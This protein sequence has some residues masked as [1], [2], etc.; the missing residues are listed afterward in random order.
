M[1]FKIIA[2]TFLSSLCLSLPVHAQF[3][4]MSVPGMGGGSSG[5]AVD[6][7]AVKK[8]ITSALTSMAYA[9]AKYA[10]AVGNDSAAAQLKEIGDKLKSGSMGVNSD[11]IGQLK[12]ASAP[13]N[14]AIKKSL[15]EKTKLSDAGKKVA[16]EGFA[17]HVT[18]SIEAFGS[19]KQL[20][21]ALE[22]KSPMALSALAS[23]SDYPAFVA[24]W[25]TATVTI[26]SYLSANG[27]DIKDA[28]KKIKD[29][30]AMKDS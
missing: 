29:S 5:P 10:Q 2:L 21:K 1:K 18:G 27:I 24:Q 28:D 22:S 3:G 11:S 12:T 15:D 23:L 19:V 9:N 8:L 6:T 20:K 26:F 30:A 16:L 13:V 25:G 14:D 4:G 7:D 17:L